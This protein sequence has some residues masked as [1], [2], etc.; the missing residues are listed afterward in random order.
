ME[1]QPTYHML[2]ARITGPVVHAKQLSGGLSRSQ[3]VMILE[4]W[5]EKTANRHGVDPTDYTR[6]IQCH[7]AGIFIDRVK[8]YAAVW[9]SSGVYYHLEAHAGELD[10][11]VSNA[12]A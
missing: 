3:V 1:P 6:A 12:S 2:A 10:R 7:P 8:L 4:S 11:K 5:L 9:C